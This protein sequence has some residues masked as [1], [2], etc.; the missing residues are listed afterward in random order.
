MKIAVKTREKKL[1]YQWRE[2][3]KNTKDVFGSAK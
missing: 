1:Q 2:L 3:R